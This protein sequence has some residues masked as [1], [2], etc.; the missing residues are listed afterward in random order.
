[1][2]EGARLGEKYV[3]EV[4]C[5]RVSARFMKVHGVLCGLGR[6]K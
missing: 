6:E 5:F 2:I 1:M 3:V 4:V